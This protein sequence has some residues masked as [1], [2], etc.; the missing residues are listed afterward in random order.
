MADPTIQERINPSLLDKLT[1]EAPDKKVESRDN[2]AISAE[3]LRQYVLRDLNWL[4][5]ASQHL[6]EE[7]AAYPAVRH[8]VLNYGLPALS[9]RPV[10]GL[11]LDEVAGLLRQSIVD[12][13]PRLIPNTVFVWAEEVE[14]E[15]AQHNIVAFRIKADMW[16]QPVPLE[17]FLRT[18]VDLESGQAQVLQTSGG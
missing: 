6:D 9:G 15:L 11:D 14:D 2:R 3:R 13:E 7:I 4:F 12:F 17:L 5:N 18:Q 10:G 1:D 16:A 8:S